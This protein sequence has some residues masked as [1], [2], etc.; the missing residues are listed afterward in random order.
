VPKASQLL[1]MVLSLVLMLPAMSHAQNAVVTTDHAKATLMAH[2]PQGIQAGKSAWLGLAIAHNP[3]WHTYWK[4]PG[5]SGLPTTL[6][7][8][9][10]PGFAAGEI[11]WPTPHPLPLGPLM[12]YGYT[13]QLLLPVQLTVPANFKGSTLEVSLH[14]EWLICKEI[15]L[16]ESGDFKLSIPVGAPV[17][18]NQSLFNAARAAQPVHSTSVNTVARIDGNALVLEVSGL[19]AT[20]RGKPLQYFSEAPGVIDHAKKSEQ[21]W[22]G[23]RL[24][25]RVPLSLQRSES[26]TA[27]RAVL[28]APGQEAG[29]Q[30]A[31]TLAGGWPAGAAASAPPASAGSAPLAAIPASAPPAATAPSFL[32]SL[33]FA[34]VGGIL[35]NLMP[36][37]FPILSLKVL[38]FAQHSGARRELAAGGMAYSAGVVVSFVAL[39]GLLIVLRG[40]GEQLGWG[41]Q[42]QSPLFVAALAAL[43]TLIGLNLAGL[44]EFGSVLPGSVSAFR[45]RHRLADDALSG[46]LAVAVASPCT[47]PFMGA[48]LGAALTLSAPATLTIFAALGLGMAA[49]YL[50]A[51]LWPGVARLMPRPGMWLLRFKMLMAF[52]MFATVVWLLWVLG[53]QVGNDGVTATLALLVSLAFAAWTL[54]TPASRKARAWLAVCGLIVF[55]GVLAWAWPALKADA[56]STAPAQQA[57][58]AKW[59]PWSPAAVAA[60]RQQGRPVFV[61]FT[62]AWC[63]T[64]QFNKKAVLSDAQ[65]LADLDARRVVLLRAD[66]TRRDP[67]ITQQLTQLGRSGVPVYALYGPGAGEPQI[68]SEILSVAQVRAALE[69]M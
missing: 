63:V 50:A 24:D 68:L 12:N 44:F 1:A 14:A 64:C 11:E 47:A 2:A 59:Q 19:P 17:V 49:P 53:Q 56:G 65:L 55:S 31:F 69:K 37:V 51:S 10:P 32:L 33:L 13:G 26:P 38:A 35:L 67:V 6:S 54:A 3:E 42:L 9:L 15:C 28:A 7:W 29:V 52:P 30:L 66:W 20:L 43:F 21:K 39:A 48:A 5:D 41:F 18:A 22:T 23:E 57:A 16:P 46:A 40:A 8:T 34:F 62:A 60:A 27:M 45:A 36:C 4:N 25:L 61:D 58:E